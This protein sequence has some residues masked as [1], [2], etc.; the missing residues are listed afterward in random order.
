MKLIPWILTSIFEE[1]IWTTP[2]GNKM[3]SH[4]MIF[5]LEV[6]THLKNISQIGSFPQAGVKIKNIWVAT[7]QF[8]MYQRE[9]KTWIVNPWP[10]KS[11]WCYCAAVRRHIRSLNEKTAGQRS[12]LNGGKDSDLFWFGSDTLRILQN[13][14]GSQKQAARGVTFGGSGHSSYTVPSQAPSY[15]F[16]NWGPSWNDLYNLL[17]WFWEL[18]LKLPWVQKPPLPQCL[19]L[20]ANEKTRIASVLTKAHPNLF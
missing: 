7:T 9:G 20:E 17:W 14:M 5:W 10:S 4:D 6:S 1:K 19:G 2:T 12:R 11:G 15:W 18:C 16:Y 3:E 8:C 13:V